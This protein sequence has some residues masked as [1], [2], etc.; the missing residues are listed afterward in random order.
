M[1]RVLEFVV[2][3]IM[4]IVLAV[5]VGLFLPSHAHIERSIDISH[6]PQHIY[7]ALNNFRRFKDVAG[8]GLAVNDNDLKVDVSGPAYGPG[9]TATWQG[10]AAVG[11]GTLVNKSDTIDLAK[12][13]KVVWDLTNDWH[14]H[15]KTFTITLT[16]KD[17]QRVSTVTWSYDVDYGWNLIGRYSALW[18]HGAPSQ[19]VQYGLDSLQ[20]MMASIDNIGYDK[21]NPAIYKVPATPM[22]LVSTKAK[23]SMDDIDT[24]KAAAYKEL[25]SAMAKLG[26]K[27]AG[28]TTTITTNYGAETYVFDVAVPI[29]TTTLTI[30]GESHDLTQL[31]AA[32]TAADLMAQPDTSAPSSAPASSA[33][34]AAPTLAVGTLDKLNQLVVDTNVR[35]VMRPA[36]EVLQANWTGEVGLAA[37][38]KALKAYAT[39]HGYAF[40]PNAHRIYAE[41]FSLPTVDDQDQAFRVYLPVQD[42]PAQT[43]EQ[44]AGRSPQLTAPNP[45]LWAG[46]AAPAP[47]AAEPAKE[48]KKAEPR[49]RPAHHERR[50]RG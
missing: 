9:A 19:M 18:I 4:V 15:D 38:R 31:P 48:T 21:L 11:N 25:Q 14:G 6:N 1:T 39:T 7:D 27:Q 26:V 47:A 5:I 23:R 33:P 29:D 17:G 30:A 3:L 34:A 13:A 43:P 36:E 28:P 45:S 49:K 10:N 24:A 35:A 44:K 22:L 40:D 20:T 2:A 41:L 46:A 37:I 42:A 32:P 50:R 8:A 16:P 12:N